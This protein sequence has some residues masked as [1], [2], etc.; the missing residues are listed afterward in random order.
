VFYSVEV[1]HAGVSHYQD[2]GD[3]Q[4]SLQAWFKEH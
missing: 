3:D 4:V 2:R 1:Q